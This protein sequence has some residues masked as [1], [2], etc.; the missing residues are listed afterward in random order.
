M[1]PPP[2]QHTRTYSRPVFS[3][4][5]ASTKFE[6]N[7]LLCLTILLMGQHDIIYITRSHNALSRHKS[8]NELKYLKLEKRKY[9]KSE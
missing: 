3:E 8:L 6:K 2:S 7:T 9:Q 4:Y 1:L 5:Y